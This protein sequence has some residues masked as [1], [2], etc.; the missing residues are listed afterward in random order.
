[1][2]LC[3]YEGTAHTH[4]FEQALIAL[5]Q[6]LREICTYPQIMLSIIKQQPNLSVTVRKENLLQCNHVWVLQLS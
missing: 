3:L 5:P 4:Q 2:H 6:T 1:M